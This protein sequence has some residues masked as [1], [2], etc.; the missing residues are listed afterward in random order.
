MDVSRLKKKDLKAWLPLDD[1]GDVEILCRHI[2]QSEFDA[3]D[4]AAT[5]KKGTRD[6]NKF[7]SDL[8][9]AVVQDWRGIDDDGADYP[10]TPDNID[11]LMEEST[12]FRLLI[13]D[14]P[15]SMKKMLAA[16]REDIRKKSLPTSEQKQITPALIVNS[17]EQTKQP[18]E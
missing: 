11:Y 1:D 16:E 13:M 4:E 7:R 6:N 8:A 18:T 3:I 14:A 9:K 17:A 2:S 12:S 15:L 10:C 5:D